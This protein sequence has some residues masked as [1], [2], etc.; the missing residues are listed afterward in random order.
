MTDMIECPIPYWRPDEVAECLDGLSTQTRVRLWDISNELER[1]GKAVP[2]GGD[3]SN[4]T[5]EYPPEPDAFISGK[6]QS[7]WPTL[8]DDERAEIAACYAKKDAS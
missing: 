5:I 2:L 8:T 3:G 4:G 6:M 1:T 7:L